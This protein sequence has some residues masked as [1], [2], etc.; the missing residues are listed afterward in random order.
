MK[1]LKVVKIGGNVL[2][3]PPALE[4]FLQDFAAL[5]G[6]K[7]LVHGGGKLATRTGERLGIAARMHEGR[8]ITDA[9]TLEV[10]TMVYA[11][12][13]SKQLA[14]KL[15][16]LGC[17][18]AGLSGADLDL[19]RSAKRPPQPVD[20]GFV[21]DV[22]QVNSQ[23]LQLLTEGGA[24]PVLN[25]ITHNGQGQLLN[26]NADT[27]AAEVA[28]AAGSFAE[29]EL[30]YCF[31]KPGVMRDPEDDSTCIPEINTSLYRQLLADGT[32]TAGMKPK[33]QNCFFALEKGV[34]EVRIIQASNLGQLVSG[35]ATGTR[36]L[37]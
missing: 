34:K 32:I 28:I 19:V 2:D 37:K 7:I 31:E 8:R 23:A 13:V 17:P 30:I 22:V 15:H 9:P 1:K 21:G 4:N 25:A 36:L 20:F 3:N 24:V 18:A 14:A 6:P 12:L 33:L 27:I 11:G 26:T 10:V 35:R 16:A 5:P 29:V